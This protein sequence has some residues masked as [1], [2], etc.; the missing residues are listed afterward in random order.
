MSIES[1]QPNIPETKTTA[2][3]MQEL[4]VQVVGEAEDYEIKPEDR[5]EN[6]E[7]LV[8][9]EG[10]I[11]NL[12]KQSELWWKIARTESFKS[13]FGDWQNE[14]EAASK[15]LDKNGEPLV[16][17]RGLKKDISAGDFYDMQNP[18]YNKPDYHMGK[19]AYFTPVHATAAAYATETG[20]VFPAFVNAKK[21]QYN[22][23]P[24]AIRELLESLKD[25]VVVKF[26]KNMLA[27]K[28][29]EIS[30]LDYDSAF[31]DEYEPVLKENTPV[32][33]VYE[34]VIKNTNQILLIPN[35][36]N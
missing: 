9:P 36:V 22:R 16:L 19:G 20:S 27:K 4:M 2:E 25:A 23:N 26:P 24:M 18:A 10:P 34:M 3:T 15:I 6:G 17:F 5:N 11:S 7:L 35:K 29:S 30:F 12:G 33:E 32:D 13:F 28:L 14:A 21:P 31:A 1:P 8:S